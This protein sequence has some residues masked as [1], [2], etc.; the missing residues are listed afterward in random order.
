MRWL[1][2][3]FL[4]LAWAAP[5]GASPRVI[6][7][8]V[9]LHSIVAAVMGRTGSPELLLKGSLSEHRASF[10]PAQIAA[11]GKADLVFI[12]GRGLESK[13]AQL[14]GS[15]AVNSK[16][17][18]AL[19]EAPGVSSL[20]IREGGAWE[21]HADDG[22]HDT[23]NAAAE[24]VL[25]ADPHVWL[26]PENAKA[27]A[28]AVAE[29]LTRADPG[30]TEA[31]AE[32]LK[33]FA[34]AADAVSRDVAAELAPVKLRPFIVFHD[35]YQYFERRFGLLAVGSITDVS[36]RAPSAERL[37]AIRDKLAASHAVCVFREPQYDARTVDAVVEGSGAKSGVLDPLGAGLEPG[38][39]AYGQLLR[40]LAGA[41]RACLAG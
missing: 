18:I 10:T 3:L 6:V 38:P 40:N 39:L 23:T 36:A 35:A 26:D 1:A 27:M 25:T 34:A 24:G 19:A 4:I 37:K 16:T 8:V 30:Q 20:P 7:S 15:E 41:L 13:L 14:S 2:I 29:E 33:A 32:N 9:P 22:D 12:A 11:L 31:Y 28:M 17:F 21:P 5:A